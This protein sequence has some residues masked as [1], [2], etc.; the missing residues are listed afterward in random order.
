MTAL[1]QEISTHLGATLSPFNAWLILRGIE[2]LPIRMAA[3][4]RSAAKV[5]EYLSR[6]PAVTGIRYPHLPSHPQYD[7]ARHQMSM[8]SGMIAFTVRDAQ[9]FGRR[10]ESRL[11]IF[12]Y[13][14]SLGHSHSLILYCD[15]ADLQRT[16][17]RLDADLLARY[18]AFAGKGFFRLSIGLE[19]TDDLCADLDRAL[20]AAG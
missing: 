8:G 4:S 20:A 3:Y 5:A 17:F 2:T 6:H 11:R 15:T 12:K 16:T 7:L 1:R 18:R 19:D 10:L 9:A 13:A 14:A